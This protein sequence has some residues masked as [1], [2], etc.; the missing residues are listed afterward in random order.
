MHHAFAIQLLK[1]ADP[2]A[3]LDTLSPAALEREAETL[4]EFA[5]ERLRADAFDVPLELVQ[6]LTDRQLAQYAAQLRSLEDYGQCD[7]SVGGAGYFPSEYNPYRVGD[8]KCENCVHWQEGNCQ[9]VAGAIDPQGICRLWIIPDD[10]LSPFEGSSAYVNYDSTRLDG[11]MLKWN[12]LDIGITHEPGMQRFPGSNPMRSFYGRINRSWGAA[13]DGKAIDAY[14]S[15]EFD[16]ATD[17]NPIYRVM[18][19]DP[20]TGMMDESK[21]F[22]GYGSPTDVKKTHI[23]HA[24]VERFGAIAQVAPSE[25]DA[26][27]KDAAYHADSCGC[28]A[29]EVKAKGRS[30]KKQVQEVEREEEP[31]RADA[32]EPDDLALLIEKAQKQ[33]R[34]A[35]AEWV[36]AIGSW[37]ATHDSLEA[38]QAAL[39]DDPGQVYDLLPGKKFEDSLYQAMLLSDLVGRVQVLDEGNRMDS[40]SDSLPRL[41]APRPEWLKL[42]FK[43][44]IEALRKRIVMPIAD[45]RDMMEGYHSWAFSISQVSRAD[46]L[47]DAQWLIDQALSNGNS[48]ETFQKQWE[49]LIGRKGWNPGE[50]RL[51]TIFDTNLRGSNGTGRGKQMQDPEV[52]SRRPYLLWR[53]RDSPNPRLNHQKMDNKAIALSSPFWQKCRF[54]CGFFC[55]CSGFSVTKDYC[56]RNNIEILNNPPDPETIAE[57]GFRYP[58]AGL[59][60]QQRQEQIDEMKKRVDPKLKSRMEAD[61]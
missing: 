36:K 11:K 26:Y 41:D 31:D 1:T 45:Y 29:C 56:D 16:P 35:V 24:G 37:M 55:R 33:A 20:A 47:E 48:F 43:Q 2:N 25:L 10:L 4:A 44:A 22:F 7:Q 53:W 28:Q 50:Q 51:Y 57:K 19:R 18:Q 17:S 32:G 38:A 6:G 9:V 49:R 60:E 34:P 30:K 13:E 21:Y 59:D 61:F 39:K 42:S 40:L 12:G 8:I 5:V 23:Y 3:R 46:I 27:R 15:P 58:L 14:I 54:P 52:A